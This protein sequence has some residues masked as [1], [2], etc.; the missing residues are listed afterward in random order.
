MLKKAISVLTALIFAFPLLAGAA[1]A[2]ELQ[3]QAQDLQKRALE[4]QQKVGVAGGGASNVQ[5]CPLFGKDMKRGSSGED[6][7]RL[8][9]FLA[10]DPGVY[11]EGQVSGT[12]GPLTEVAVKRWQ[13]KFNIVTSGNTDTTGYGAVG[14][15]TIAAMVTQ[16][17][18]STQR[19]IAAA[20]ALGWYISASPIVRY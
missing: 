19:P 15:R 11:P 3:Q 18:G 6:V 12:Y 9:Q 1:T 17:P 7:R 14:P 4:L 8:Q 20:P 13:V 5:G 10:R 2:A 16:C